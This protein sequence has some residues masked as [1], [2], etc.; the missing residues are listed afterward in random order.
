MVSF[1]FEEAAPHANILYELLSHR[2]LDYYRHFASPRNAKSKR[3]SEN[4]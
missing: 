4:D 1:V 2:K 3:T